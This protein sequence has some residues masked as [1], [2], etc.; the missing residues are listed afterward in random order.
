[1]YIKSLL[2]YFLRECQECISA[3][4]GLG[5]RENFLETQ[6]KFF[7]NSS[8]ISISDKNSLQTAIFPWNMVP[9]IPTFPMPAS[10]LDQD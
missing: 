10:W 7:F 5:K 8:C 1:M 2:K 3:W 6:S 4:P 9:K